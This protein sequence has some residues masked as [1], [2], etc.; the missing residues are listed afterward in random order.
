VGAFQRTPGAEKPGGIT[1]DVGANRPQADVTLTIVMRRLDNAWWADA[2]CRWKITKDKLDTLRLEIPSQ[3]QEPFSCS[4]QAEVQTERISGQNRRVMAIRPVAAAAGEYQVR[5]CGKLALS[6]GERVRAPDIVPLDVGRADRFLIVPTELQ[7][8]HFEWET[9]GM[10]AVELPADYAVPQYRSFV[11][12]QVT[13]PSF[14]A[15]MNEVKRDSG[16]P[17]VRLA[18]IHISCHDHHSLFGLAVFDIEPAG[19]ESC[20]VQL[21]AGY[22]LL[23]AGMDG[24][25]API[26]SAGENRWELA[27]GATQLSRRVEVAFWGPTAGRQRAILQ[28]PRIRDL[29]V[30]QTLWT[31]QGTD[32]DQIRTVPYQSPSSPLMHEQARCSNIAGL[33]EDASRVL[34]ESNPDDAAHWY[35]PWATR[36]AQARNKAMYW[37]TKGDG[38]E[39][40]RS[41]AML[42]ATD[43]RLQQIAEQL[44]VTDLQ[45]QAARN[46]QFATQAP[47]IADV[48]AVQPRLIGRWIFP[49]VAEKIEIEAT[50]ESH[51]S[52]PGRSV[53]AF[54]LLGVASLSVLAYSRREWDRWLQPYPQL[55]F[56]LAGLAWWIWLTPSILGLVCVLVCALSLAFTVRRWA[57]QRRLQREVG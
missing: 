34:A 43:Q 39:A 41:L 17:Q 46:A 24:G 37:S 48:T 22:R 18:D 53:M 42:R 29:P 25:V 32:W 40:N 11:A 51:T 6:H 4:T 19:C 13:A 49:G 27:L 44:G 12:Y 52:H 57:R 56:L 38:S 54:L 33:I 28:A 15:T 36:Y 8:R 5:I 31:V 35:L 3:W 1:V 2:D 45:E 20:V 10:R 55:L 50:E 47:D 14:Q 23:R 26:R 30:H 7:N 16:S 9:S 21:P